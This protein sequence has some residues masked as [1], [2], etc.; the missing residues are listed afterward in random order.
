[1]KMRQI[2]LFLTAL[3]MLTI[4]LAASAQEGVNFNAYLDVRAKYDTQKDHNFYLR[5]HHLG[6]VTNAVRDKTQFYAEIEYEDTPEIVVK[7]GQI[8]SEKSGDASKTNVTSAW[9]KYRFR[10]DFN[11]TAGKFLTPLSFYHQR[12]F[13]VLLTPIHRPKGVAEIPDDSMIGVKLDGRFARHDWRFR[14]IAGVTQD[15]TSQ[16]SDEDANNNNPFFG[17]LEITPPFLSDLKVGIGAMTGE[18]GRHNFD[19][20]NNLWENADKTLYAVDFDYYGSRFFIEGVYHFINV[21]NVSS[22]HEDFHQFGTHLLIRYDMNDLFSPW[23]MY[24]YADFDSSDSDIDARTGTLGL[25]I[26]F[27]D[28]LKIKTEATRQKNKK[29]NGHGFELSLVGYF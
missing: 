14:Y 23:I 2:H 27:S 17:R 19:S 18:D 4:P 24:E 25:N 15:W 26:N 13:P 29:G 5:A 9:M 1:M 22:G 20:T 11:I 16:V 6:L 21:S 28:N 8:K 7:E 10:E 12:H 3:F